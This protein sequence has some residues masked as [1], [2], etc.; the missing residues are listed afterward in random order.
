MSGRRCMDALARKSYADQDRHEKS[1][2]EGPLF[3]SATWTANG[4]AGLSP[5]DDPQAGRVAVLQF[6]NGR[7]QRCSRSVP[8]IPL[9][10]RAEGKGHRRKD[11]QRHGEARQDRLHRNH[12]DDRT[13]VLDS[14][15]RAVFRGRSL[16]LRPRLTTG[17]PWT[18]I[19]HEADFASVRRTLGAI[20]HAGHTPVVLVDL[21][22]GVS[23]RTHHRG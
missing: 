21:H 23:A 11:R 13:R 19:Q 10:P 2:P 17:L 4:P 5:S 12:L 18:V 14:G 1:G 22:C 9:D 6:G 8:P 16:A 7:L 3:M 15:D 20:G